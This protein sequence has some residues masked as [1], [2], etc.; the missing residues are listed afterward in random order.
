MFHVAPQRLKII[1]RFRFLFKSKYFSKRASPVGDR[2]SAIVSVRKPQK[3][4]YLSGII[5]L[6]I[7]RRAVSVCFFLHK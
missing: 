3:A 6:M 4:G 7:F 5:P 1:F 2:V